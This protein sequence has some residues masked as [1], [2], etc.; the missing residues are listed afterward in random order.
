MSEQKNDNPELEAITR[1]FEKIRQAEPGEPFV[2]LGPQPRN[3][4]R[5]S[6]DFHKVTGFQ[7]VHGRRGP[8]YPTPQ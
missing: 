4:N 1:I 2:G 7:G 6:P 5:T 3:T 8:F